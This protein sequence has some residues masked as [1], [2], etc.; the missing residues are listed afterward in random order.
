MYKCK[1]ERLILNLL[2]ERTIFIYNIVLS[3]QFNI[4]K[5]YKNKCIRLLVDIQKYFG[6]I[7]YQNFDT[8]SVKY[9]FHQYKILMN[10]LDYLFKLFDEIDEF[11]KIKQL[12]SD[13]FLSYNSENL[14]MML[15]NPNYDKNYIIDFTKFFRHIS[16]KSLMTKNDSN[17]MLYYNKFYLL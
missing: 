4:T 17:N 5:K 8:K 6:N 1:H 16:V 3:T 13:K 11:E 2:I 14:N 15:Y 7:R 12:I 9:E 10:R